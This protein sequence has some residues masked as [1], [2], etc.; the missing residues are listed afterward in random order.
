MMQIQAKLIWNFWSAGTKKGFWERWWFPGRIFTHVGLTWRLS[1]APAHS[2]RIV[3][4]LNIYLWRQTVSYLNSIMRAKY[5]K[6]QIY[7]S[8]K[9]NVL[10]RI[11]TKA[12][13]FSP[14]LC[15]WW[16][17][18]M[19][20][21]VINIEVGRYWGLPKIRGFHIVWA[22]DVIGQTGLSRHSTLTWN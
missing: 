21:K 10:F 16:I 8:L 4:L 13:L 19:A 15:P 14:I 9:L 7:I 20:V 12:T 17:E 22:G 6:W 1:L 11:M 5:V 18:V 2:A 3:N